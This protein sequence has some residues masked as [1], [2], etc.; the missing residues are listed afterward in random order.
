MEQQSNCIH[1]KSIYISVV[2]LCG[3]QILSKE[4][5][6]DLVTF[7]IT[8]Y[9]FLRKPCLFLVYSNFVGPGKCILG[10]RYCLLISTAPS[11][12]HWL[13]CVLF[14]ASAH[15]RQNQEKILI[16]KELMIGTAII[17]IS[18]PNIFPISDLNIAHFWSIQL[19]WSS[20]NIQWQSCIRI[21]KIPKEENTLSQNLID[22]F[23]SFRLFLLILPL[24]LNLSH[25]FHKLS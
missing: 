13:E 11:E 17:L 6:L 2:E 3:I 18:N 22:H 7:A 19:T 5:T 24:P 16:F 1:S 8:A 10:L 15:T 23:L 12:P 4:V 9:G 25:W 21:L 14:W 20:D